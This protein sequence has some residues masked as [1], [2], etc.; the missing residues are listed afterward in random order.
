MQNSGDTAP[1]W[2][3]GDKKLFSGIKNIFIKNVPSQMERLKDAFAS[4]DI[5]TIELLSHSIKGAAAMIGAMPLKEEAGKVEQAA[6]E[7][8]L[9]NA[10]VCF[11][12]MEREFKKT[13]S[14]LQS[15]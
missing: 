14:A 1:E 13:L 2:L 15:S 10:R 6:M 3:E 11:E 7:S 9:D 12:G 4:N 8:D 5:S